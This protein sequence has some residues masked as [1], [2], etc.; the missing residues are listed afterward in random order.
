MH[1]YILGKITLLINKKEWIDKYLT[2]HMRF[3]NS[4]FSKTTN[5]QSAHS[6]YEMYDASSRLQLH[7][8][9]QLY[10]FVAALF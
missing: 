10:C 9:K 2:Y 7:Q 8:C 6:K 5:L 3:K 1:E 4:V